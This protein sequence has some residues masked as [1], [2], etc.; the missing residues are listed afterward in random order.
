MSDLT[1]Q[2]NIADQKI[3]PDVFVYHDG[4]YTDSL[5]VAEYFH[6][7]HKNIIQSIEILECSEEFRELNFQP[8]SYKSKQNKKMPMYRITRDGFVFLVMGFTGKKAAAFKE[9]YIKRFNEMEKWLLARIENKQTQDFFADAVKRYEERQLPK[10]RRPHAYSIENNLVYIVALGATR[11]QWLANHGYREDDEIRPHLTFDQL[12]RLDLVLSEAMRLLN[13]GVFYKER[14]QKLQ[15]FVTG[16]RIEQL[17]TAISN[18][19]PTT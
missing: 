7:R 14:K 1:I 18:T 4:V 8:S 17:R 16:L 15:Q 2:N 13:A 3:L 11:K 19:Q 9:A 10:Y 5:K 12:K 6:K